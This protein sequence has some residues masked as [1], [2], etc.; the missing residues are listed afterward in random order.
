[1]IEAVVRVSQSGVSGFGTYLPVCDGTRHTFTVLV[2]A[3]DGVHEPGIAQALTFA[4]ID[5]AGAAF[6]GIDDDGALDIVS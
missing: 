6:F 3:S 5:Y 2:Q 4:E 1:M